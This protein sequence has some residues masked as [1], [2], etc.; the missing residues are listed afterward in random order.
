MNHHS[1]EEILRDVRSLGGDLGAELDPPALLVP[2]QEPGVAVQLQT[3]GRLVP[4][5]G[6]LREVVQRRLQTSQGPQQLVQGDVGGA[7][8]GHAGVLVGAASVDGLAGPTFLTS[9]E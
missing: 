9:N 5:V 8:L 2:D 4:R 3:N 1:S 6:R 7:A